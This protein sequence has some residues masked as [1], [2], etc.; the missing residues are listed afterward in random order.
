MAKYVLP[1]FGQLDSENINEYYDCEINFNNTNVAIDLNFGD[2]KIDI[3]RLEIAKKFLEQM[4]DYDFKNK[5][6]IEQDYKDDDCDTVREYIDHHLEELGED[7]L[8]ELIDQKNK[9]IS[10][11]DQLVKKLHLVRMGL[12]PDS[13]DQF[14]IFDYSIGPE[15]TQYL[16]VL[17]VDEFGN[18]DYITMES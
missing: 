15:I 8:S 14:A 10:Q 3:G 1:H 5:K 13:D 4:A 2:T 9:K 7:E 6:Y 11:G 17:F 16:V 18:L 12:Y